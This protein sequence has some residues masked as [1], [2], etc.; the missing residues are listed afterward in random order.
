MFISSFLLLAQISQPMIMITTVKVKL[1]LCFTFGVYEKKK[2]KNPIPSGWYSSGKLFLTFSEK[3]SFNFDF[4]Y[5]HYSSTMLL[6]KYYSNKVFFK[7]LFIYHLFGYPLF[8][9]VLHPKKKM[10]NI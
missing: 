8:T 1:T 9:T 4:K 2:K 6:W 5:H 7:I 3:I 10:K